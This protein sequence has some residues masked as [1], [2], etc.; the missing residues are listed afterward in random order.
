[1]KAV[2]NEATERSLKFPCL[3]RGRLSGTIVLMTA[4]GK[5]TAV[6]VKDGGTHELGEHSAA[7]AM[8]YLAPFH[9]TITLE[10]D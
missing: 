10:S 7:W 8:D 5:G 1:M 6:F 3:M 9:G 2:V 4:P